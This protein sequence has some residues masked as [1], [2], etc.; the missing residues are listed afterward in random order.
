M[1]LEP[2]F[3][4]DTHTNHTHIA[5]IHIIIRVSYRIIHSPSFQICCPNRHAYIVYLLSIY[6]TSSCAPCQNQCL[7]CMIHQSA[8]TPTQG[9]HR[10]RTEHTHPGPNSV[11]LRTAKPNLIKKYWFRL[12]Q[13]HQSS[14]ERMFG[15][16]FD[17]GYPNQIKSPTL[18]SQIKQK[19]NS[20]S[21]NL[22]RPTAVCVSNWDDEMVKIRAIHEKLLVRGKKKKRKFKSFWPSIS[23]CVT[24]ETGSECRNV[25]SSIE[26]LFPFRWLVHFIY[27]RSI[28]LAT[29]R[30]APWQ[31][32]IISLRP[33]NHRLA[34]SL[35]R[36]TI[37]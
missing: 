10:T 20:L 1:Q 30:C 24:T 31:R 28:S 33:F 11:L 8:R 21:S 4:V 6:I 2:V 25:F 34:L 7:L 26:S 32:R 23:K 19:T 3:C 9:T 17:L 14:P 18:N 29:A 35:T 27:K 22:F 16:E 13:P 15:E 5:T 36:G 12:L 37:D